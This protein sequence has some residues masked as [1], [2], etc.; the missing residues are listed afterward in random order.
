MKKK[1][2]PKKPPA[3]IPA[4]KKPSKQ[5]LKAAKSGA[6]GIAATT[7]GRART[8]EDKRKA[9]LSAREQ[10]EKELEDTGE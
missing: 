10:I 7:R 5:T 3:K 8:F 6:A 9:E 2:T 4:A 1:T